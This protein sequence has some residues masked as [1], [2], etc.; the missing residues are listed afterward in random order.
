MTDDPLTALSASLGCS[1]SNGTCEDCAR[2]MRAQ[3]LRVRQL[4][5]PVRPTGL[6]ICYACSSLDVMPSR[7]KEGRG[8]AGVAYPCATIR[9]LDGS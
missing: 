6:E 4:H 7:S 8:R 2:D 3:I 1:C 9:T 5:R